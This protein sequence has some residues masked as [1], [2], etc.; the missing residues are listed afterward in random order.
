[1][2]LSV[3]TVLFFLAFAQ[4]SWGQ[5]NG[6]PTPTAAEN[7]ALD[8]GALVVIGATPEQEAS[9]RSQIQIMHPEVLPLRVLSSRTGS[10]WM[11]PG[12]FS[13]MCPRVSAA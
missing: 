12:H 9:L 13:F 7:A 4:F 2:K 1:M 10:T 8:P 3:G 5:T 6:V 11:P